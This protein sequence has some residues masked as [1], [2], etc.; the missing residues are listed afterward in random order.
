MD[1]FGLHVRSLLDFSLVWRDKAFYVLKKNGDMKLSISYFVSQSKRM[2]RVEYVSDCILC[3]HIPETKSG[4]FRG[5]C[6]HR[7]I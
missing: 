3:M 4:H 2:S 6:Q 5:N 7:A 1:V